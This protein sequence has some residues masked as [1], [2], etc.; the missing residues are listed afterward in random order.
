MGVLLCAKMNVFLLL[1]ETKNVFLLSITDAL[2]KI[3][4]FFMVLIKCLR[5]QMGVPFTEQTI[6]TFI[7]MF[8]R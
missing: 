7:H 6:S 2:L 1:K 3:V 8:S 5:V 4:E